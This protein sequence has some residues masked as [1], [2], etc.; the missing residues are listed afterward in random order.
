MKEQCLQLVAAMKPASFGPAD[1]AGGLPQAPAAAAPACHIAARCWQKC[2]LNQPIQQLLLLLGLL[3]A[4][5]QKYNGPE[6]AQSLQQLH[7]AL[8]AQIYH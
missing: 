8:E 4:S 7:L 1:V 3:A 6:A 5:C 2:L